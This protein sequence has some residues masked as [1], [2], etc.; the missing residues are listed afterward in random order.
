[1][2]NWQVVFLLAWGGNTYNGCPQKKTSRAE[3]CRKGKECIRKPNES[4][5]KAE[6]QSVF[7]PGTLVGKKILMGGTTEPPNTRT[8]PSSSDQG[9]GKSYGTG[10]GEG[11]KASPTPCGF[12]STIFNQRQEGALNPG[13]TSQQD[14]PADEDFLSQNKEWERLTTTHT[15]YYV[16]KGEMVGLEE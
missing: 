5:G 8:M 2:R 6:A 13:Q 14:Q 1:V 7:S 9:A 10:R 3:S 16:M 15:A 11:E 4:L 12:W